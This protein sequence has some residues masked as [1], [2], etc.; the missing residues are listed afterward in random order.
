MRVSGCCQVVV[1]ESFVVNGDGGGHDSVA[2]G[3]WAIEPSPWD[4]GNETVAA[5]LGDETGDTGASSVGL[6]GVRR[7]LGIEPGYQRADTTVVGANVA[8]PSDAGLLGKGV[9][10]LAKLVDKLK[11]EFGYKG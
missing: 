9:A 7:W 4:S 11:V 6:L 10:K 1:G 5:K 3:A 8:H 2:I